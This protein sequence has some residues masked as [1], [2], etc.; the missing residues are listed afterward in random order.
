[1]RENNKKSDKIVVSICLACVFFVF[2]SAILMAF[3]RLVL[4]KKFGI[5]NAFT[6]ILFAG[7][8][9]LNNGDEYADAD[10]GNFT[11]DIDWR[12]LY[13]FMYEDGEVVEEK[14]TIIDTYKDLVLQTEDR[15]SPYV[16]KFIVGYDKEIELAKSY[17]SLIGWN[18]VSFS[19]YNGISMMSDGY[20]TEFNEEKETDEWADSLIS[21][22]RFVKNRGIE[23][24]YIQAPYKVSEYDDADISGYVDFSN[25]NANNM[26]NIASASEVDVCDLRECIH[27]EGIHNHDMFY[28]TDHHWLTTSG[29]WGAQ[30]I[31]EYCNGNYGFKANTDILDI[32][33]FEQK[34][35]PEWFLG[36]QGKKV[37]LSRTTP[38]DFVLLYPKYDTE[39]HYVVPARN[40]DDVGDY[41]ICYD[42]DQIEK[43]DLYNLNPYGGCNYGDQPVLTIDNTM[44]NDDKKILI[45]HDSFGDC[46]ISALALCEKRVDSLDI[47]HFTG[48]VESYIKKADPDIVMVMYNAGSI[49]G[50]IDWSSHQ[51]TFDFR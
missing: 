21:F 13:P 42:M 12:S 7:N 17:E 51:S 16:S 43:K 47:R 44:A 46:L 41:S 27:S 37:T 19:E 9:I 5:K 4:V 22:N 36:S 23:F 6:D 33:Q 28:R 34:L 20:L 11:A 38:D 26:I 24:L 35:Y 25:Q 30:R 31:L 2:F 50:E 39:F 45:I 29:L 18:F 32:D 40:I 1:M 14:N 49:G 48:S 15:I 10:Q 8:D 3:T